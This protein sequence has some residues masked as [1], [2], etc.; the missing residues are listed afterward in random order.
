MRRAFFILTLL[1]ATWARAEPYALVG[2][3]TVGET[4]VSGFS[5]PTLPVWLGAGYRRGSWAVEA[6]YANLTTFQHSY[7][8]SN[9]TQNLFERT[10]SGRGVGAFGVYYVGPFFVRA[11]AYHLKTELRVIDRV[12]GLDESK[13]ST[14]WAPLLGFGWEG[15]LSERVTGRLSA[16]YVRGRDEFRGTSIGGLSLLYGF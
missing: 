13:N 3:G 15:Q 5:D 16:E 1:L 2:V 12:A 14:F 4:N 8:I 9:V 10:W 11:G 6:A 7:V